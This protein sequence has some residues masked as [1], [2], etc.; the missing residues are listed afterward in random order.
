MPLKRPLVP[1]HL[2][3]YDYSTFNVLSAA[4]GVVYYS[5]SGT[6]CEI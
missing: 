6:L 4:G 1:M 5:M 3:N 2:F